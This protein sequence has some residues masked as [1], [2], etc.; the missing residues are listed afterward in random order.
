M[1]LLSI[2]SGG[3]S[4]VQSLHRWVLVLPDGCIDGTDPPEEEAPM[5]KSVDN[6]VW[7]SI[8]S[9]NYV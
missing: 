7:M 1:S 2:S 5:K 9:L 6:A 4:Y 3:W 8:L